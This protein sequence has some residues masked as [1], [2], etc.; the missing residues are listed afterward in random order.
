MLKGYMVKKMLDPLLNVF[1]LK[2]PGVF[3]CIVD[4]HSS[5]YAN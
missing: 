1:L 4:F 3:V 5:E 2:L